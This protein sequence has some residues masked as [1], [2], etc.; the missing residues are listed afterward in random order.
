MAAWFN[1][2]PKGM[3]RRAA[4]RGDL[5]YE[6]PIRFVPEP[7][8]TEGDEGTKSS[9]VEVSIS[10]TI[11]Q[12]GQTYRGGDPESF[13]RF[14]LRVADI[15]LKK[16]L[17]A[18][19]KEFERVA[20]AAASSYTRLKSQGK[21]DRAAEKL[22]AGKEAKASARSA[23]SEM[24]AIYES[25]L[26][27]NLRSTWSNL[28]QEYC[29]S[30]ARKGKK[31]TAA[32]VTQV[33]RG[34]SPKTFKECMRQ[35]LLSQ[36]PHDSAEKHAHY[37]RYHVKKPDTMSMRNFCFRLCEINNYLPL[38]P[39]QAEV[40]PQT[41]LKL[42]NVAYTEAE[43]CTMLLRMVTSKVELSY[44][45]INP[46][47]FPIDLEEL[48]DALDRIEVQHASVEANKARA[49]DGAIRS[50][51]E[52]G[53]VIS[54][55]DRRE[56]AK[57]ARTPGANASIPRKSPAKTQKHC[58]LCKQ[59]GGSPNTHNTNECNRYEKDGSRKYGK[60]GGKT[61]A[62]TEASVHTKSDRAQFAQFMKDTN[63]SMKKLTKKLA[64]KRKRKY[65]SDSSD[66][67]SD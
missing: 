34:M 66:S 40:Q 47:K 16:D 46:G 20:S 54:R 59:F 67:D 21:D 1:I 13:V 26:D 35:H 49:R 25:M 6:Y 38:L 30:T 23:V 61:G 48:R 29:N 8:S 58:V 44:L 31:A 9:T 33:P 51:K 7:S 37:I 65:S 32:T 45:A 52:N 50:T 15:V 14:Q 57:A 64:G 22:E 4:E 53:E 55:K 12:K 41:G 17:D 27:E 60:K 43:L 28:V 10:E 39:C 11:R 42:A 5:R 63:K 19:V 36:L 24:F 18:Q 2:F 56:R 3:S 62:R